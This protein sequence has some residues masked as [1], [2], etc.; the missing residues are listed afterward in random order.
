MRRACWFNPNACSLRLLTWRGG[1][2]FLFGSTFASLIFNN[3]FNFFRPRCCTVGFFTRPRWFL[4]AH[5]P[6]RCLLGRVQTPVYRAWCGDTGTR[7][8]ECLGWSQGAFDP[9]VQ[10]QRV[11]CAFA[12]RARSPSIFYFCRWC[13]AA[14]LRRCVGMWVRRCVVVLVRGCVVL[15]CR[16]GALRCCV[17][18]WSVGL[19]A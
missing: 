5:S 2:V 3:N 9:L 10:F 14:S 11:Q 18:C 7:V 6:R 12:H 19:L 4:K 17:V 15:W 1:R 8:P 16:V 13:V